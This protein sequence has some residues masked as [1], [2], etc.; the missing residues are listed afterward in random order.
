M[1]RFRVNSVVLVGGIV[2]W[3]LIASCGLIICLGFVG[4]DWFVVG[5][6]WLLVVVFSRSFIIFVLLLWITYL[7]GWAVALFAFC[8]GLR[9]L[10]VCLV[11]C[12]LFVRFYL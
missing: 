4:A 12:L 3:F 1:V 8:F 7:C 2:V 9:L 5:D 10:V 6:D 11:A